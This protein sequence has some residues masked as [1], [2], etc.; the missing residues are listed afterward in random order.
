MRRR[1][2]IIGMAGSA[3]SW[4]TAARAQKDGSVYRIGFLAPSGRDAPPIVAF[5]NELRL[6]GF[7]EGRNL[8]IIPGGFDL[9][10]DQATKLAATIVKA[11]PDV[12]YSGGEIATR[13][14]QAETKSLPVVA[15][16]SDLVAEKLVAS[17][18]R[19]GGNIT[20][21][22]ILAPELDSKRL[23]I[24]IEAVPR[25]RR[26]AILADA[27]ITPAPHLQS[28]HDAAQARGIELSIFAV[29]KP[30]EIA[31]AMEQA[32]AAGAGAL[33]VLASPLFGAYPNRA[34]IVGYPVRLQLPA[35]YEWPEIAE[36]GGLLAYG[37]RFTGIFRQVARLAA[38]VLR[39]AKPSDV[40]VEQPT[41]FELVI[42]MKTAKSI[43]HEIPAGL[44]LRA[45]KV[46]E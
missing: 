30:D 16:S 14:V 34:V 17:L 43:G 38:K 8:E 11:A 29:S 33:N 45:D 39:G 3:A 44:A 27:K 7:V 35:I 18:A 22:S 24:L 46:I 25:A 10:S 21:V 1:D 41:T 37:P 2:F 31:P 6:N 4:P 15:V 26:I 13:A 36:E 40:P 12:I 19:P 5:L 28:L 42:N 32:K 20:G 23:G 9:R